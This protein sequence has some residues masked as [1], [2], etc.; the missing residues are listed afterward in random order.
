MIEF[1]SMSLLD[2]ILNL[3]PPRRKRK[4]AELW[5]AIEYL[6]EHP[7]A[8]CKIGQ[9]YIPNGHGLSQSWIESFFKP[10]V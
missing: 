10:A 7:E 4:N 3:W 2:H 5:T 9:T 8:S 1:K 6:V